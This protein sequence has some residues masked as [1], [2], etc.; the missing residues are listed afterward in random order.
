[1]VSTRYRFTSGYVSELILNGLRRPHGLLNTYVE[2]F[3]SF[4]VTDAPLFV[5]SEGL[6]ALPI[7]SQYKLDFSKLKK[8][9]S[10]LLNAEQSYDF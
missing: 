8:S 9:T 6:D 1:M 2:H 3:T 7:L 4:K 5:A 10:Y